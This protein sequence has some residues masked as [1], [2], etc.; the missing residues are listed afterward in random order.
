MNFYFTNF[1]ILRK[2]YGNE[3]K[4]DKDKNDQGA[5]INRHSYDEMLK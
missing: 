5:D 1:Y 2:Q 4:E 3:D